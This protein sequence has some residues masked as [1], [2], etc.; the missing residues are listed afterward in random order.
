MHG[1]HAMHVSRLA[2]EIKD[3]DAKAHLLKEQVCRVTHMIPRE[4]KMSID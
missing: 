1:N 3:L 4:E 2:S